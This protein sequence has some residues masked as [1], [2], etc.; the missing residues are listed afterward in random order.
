MIQM[1]EQRVQTLCGQEGARNVQ[2]WK[3]GWVG[4]DES[5]EQP[6]GKVGNRRQVTW[7][8][9]RHFGDSFYVS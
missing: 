9:K 7:D 3:E 8:L 5:E 4:G 6:E 1:R 2:D